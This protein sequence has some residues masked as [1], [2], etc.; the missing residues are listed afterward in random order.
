MWLLP[1]S[2]NGPHRS[3]LITRATS[4][5]SLKLEPYFSALVSAVS[6]TSLTV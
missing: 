3:A 1:S 2:V 4:H 5:E 6:V